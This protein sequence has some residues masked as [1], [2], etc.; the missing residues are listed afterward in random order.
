[1]LSDA[2]PY[3]VILWRAAVDDCGDRI[4]EEVVVEDSGARYKFLELL[5]DG[6]LADSRITVDI[7]KA[8]HCCPG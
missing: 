6:E 2:G 1:M 5:P 3:F 8:R 7:N 4:D